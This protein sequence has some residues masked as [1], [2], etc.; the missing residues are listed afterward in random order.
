MSIDSKFVVQSV[1][2]ASAAIDLL[3][4]TDVRVSYMVVVTGTVTYSIQ[5]SLGDDEFIDNTDTINQTTNQDGNYVMPVQKIRV[6][7]TAGTGSVK[8]HVRQLVV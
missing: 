2:G 3:G 1:V 6:N 8:L 7:V 4:T 5:H